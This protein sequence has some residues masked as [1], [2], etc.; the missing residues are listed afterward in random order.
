M[1]V[2]LSGYAKPTPIQKNTIPISM[3]KRDLMACAQTGSGK[4]ASFLLPAVTRLI[5]AEKP[6]PGRKATPMCLIL[7]PTRE[8]TLQIFF[9]GDDVCFL[10]ILLL[11]LLLFL[12]LLFLAAEDDDRQ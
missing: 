12:L 11:H 8:L 5:R 6:P 1:N 2:E 9:V 10:S 3:A 7:S 4:T